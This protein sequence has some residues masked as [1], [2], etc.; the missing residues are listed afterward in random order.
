MTEPNEN[1]EGAEEIDVP[2]VPEP[3]EPEEGV[4]EPDDYTEGHG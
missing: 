4:L 2:P 1:E 3:L